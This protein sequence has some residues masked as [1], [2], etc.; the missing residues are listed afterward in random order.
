[1]KRFKRPNGIGEILK[2][3]VFFALVTSF[4]WMPFVIIA[5]GPQATTLDTNL[6]I[7]LGIPSPF[8]VL[9]YNDVKE[10]IFLT[11]LFAFIAGAVCVVW[12]PGKE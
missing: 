12:N 5:I 10:G 9:A 4:V 8:E 1:M 6:A 2:F 11:Y 7:G 3:V